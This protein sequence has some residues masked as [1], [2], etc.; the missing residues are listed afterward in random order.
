MRD[1]WN[2]RFSGNEYVYGEEPNTFFAEELQKY[3]PGAL[4]LPGEGE[5]RNAV[6]AAV[7]GWKPVAVDW[8]AAG[9]EK[10]EKLAQKNETS[11][12]YHIADL[13]TYQPEPQSFDAAALLFVHLP[14]AERELL[15][16]SVIE[17]LKPGGVI[18]LEAFTTEQ[19]K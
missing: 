11:I 19:L 2:S 18:I 16:R 14:P 6:F 1:F 4:Y 8:S 17:A 5:G 7:K 9:K 12:T 15:H 10:A 13:T 3:Q